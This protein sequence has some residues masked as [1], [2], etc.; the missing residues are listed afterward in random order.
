[1]ED[2]RNVNTLKTEAVLADTV[3]G[4]DDF[5]KLVN[6]GDSIKDGAKTLRV[7]DKVYEMTASGDQF[8]IHI[9]VR[10]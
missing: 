2:Q 5:R 1:M 9:Y 4:W 8:A 6:I 10:D 7:S 3:V